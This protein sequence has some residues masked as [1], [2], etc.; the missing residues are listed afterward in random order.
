M[1]V[2]T[3]KL[4]HSDDHDHRQHRHANRKKVKKGENCKKR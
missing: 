2:F 3:A 1:G 4:N